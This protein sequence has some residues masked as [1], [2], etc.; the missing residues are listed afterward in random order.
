MTIST[1]TVAE[2]EP[3]PFALVAP[4]RRRVSCAPLGSP[5][6]SPPAPSRPRDTRASTTK[7]TLRVLSHKKRSAFLGKPY[8]FPF[9]MKT[10][11]F[12]KLIK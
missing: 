9:C 5:Q 2:P 11:T 12:H 7:N 10:Y 6:G 4:P 3:E 8:D 1:G